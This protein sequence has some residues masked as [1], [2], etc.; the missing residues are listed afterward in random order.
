MI[1]TDSKSA[2]KIKKAWDT[3]IS[4]NKELVDTRGKIIDAID[5]KRRASIAEIKEIIRPFLDGASDIYTFKSILDGYNKR[6]NWWGFSATKG[7]MFFNL[8]TKI[9]DEEIGPLTSLIK[10]VIQEP[11]DL[12]VGLEKIRALEEYTKEKYEAAPDK[13]KVANPSSVAYFLTY[14]W[15]IYSPEK[16]QIYYTSLVNAYEGIGVFEK[17][18]DQ[19]ENYRNFYQVNEEIKDFLSQYTG[20]DIQNWDVEHTFWHVKQEAKVKGVK[21]EKKKDIEIVDS[22]VEIVYTPNFNVR[23]YSIPRVA[24]LLEIGAD[25]NKSG[26]RKGS[27]FEKKVAEVFKLLDFDVEELG[28][29]TGRNPDAILRFRSENIAF[30]V[31]AKAYSNGYSLGLDDRAIREYIHYYCPI[32]DKQGY[33]KIGFIIVCNSFKS[34]FNSL[35]NDLTWN[36]PIKRFILLTTDALLH[37]LA[38]K[39]KDGLDLTKIVDCLIKVGTVV[40]ASHVVQEFDDV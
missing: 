16:W 27:E 28:Q 14:F 4:A 24:N 33:K 26:A 36:T 7:Q 25:T 2:S 19:V 5:D 21:P 15:Q 18:Q 31:D 35:I 32:L 37:L 34:D 11:K 30:I 9:D 22:T 6:N 1:A 40:E 39:I 3:Y 8:L 10:S 38:Y 23:D 20:L 12:Q 17:T 29:G 13:R